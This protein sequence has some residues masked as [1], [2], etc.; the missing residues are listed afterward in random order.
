MIAMVAGTA[1]ADLI[2]S[3]TSNAVLTLLGYGIPW[4]RM[5][6]SRATTGLLEA[7]AWATSRD[8]CILELNPV[9]ITLSLAWPSPLSP[10][11][12]IHLP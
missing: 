8:I 6:L 4:H 7:R 11:P 5:V 10:P 12:H 2:I 1:P 3:S 9:I